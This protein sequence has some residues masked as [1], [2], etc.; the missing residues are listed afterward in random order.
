MDSPG[1]W[2]LMGET[3]IDMYDPNREQP[4]LVQAGDYSRCVPI[5]IMDYYDIRRAVLDGK[6]QIEVTEE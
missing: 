5:T 1:G 4:I 3:P 6:Y 2:R